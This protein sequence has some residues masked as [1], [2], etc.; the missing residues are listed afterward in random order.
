MFYQFKNPP[1]WLLDGL[2][3]EE[4]KTSNRTCPDCGVPVGKPH[5][6]CCDVAR[7]KACEGQRLSCDCDDPGE[8]I[9]TGLWPGI[10]ESYEHKLICFDTA[11][12]SIMFDLSSNL[13][14]KSLNA[15]KRN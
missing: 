11:T 3:E 2:F 15:E 13:Q 6:N 4:K 10:K 5:Q 12:C 8:D 14:R 1:Q 9:W 7:C